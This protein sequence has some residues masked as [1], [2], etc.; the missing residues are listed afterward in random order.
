MHDVF[1]LGFVGWCQIQ[2]NCKWQA[3]GTKPLGYGKSFMA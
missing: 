3:E 1:L 2:Q